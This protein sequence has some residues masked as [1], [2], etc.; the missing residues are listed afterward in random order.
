MDDTLSIQSE[1]AIEEYLLR[2]L[3]F[4]RV[5]EMVFKNRVMGPF[6]DAVPGLHDLIQLGKVFDLEL[7]DGEPGAVRARVEEMC[8]KLLAN[9]VI[10][11][12][13]VELP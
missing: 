6:L 11:S 1:A 9:T 12:F 3:R 8:K 2:M 7:Q 13:R 5:Y 10:E 4:R